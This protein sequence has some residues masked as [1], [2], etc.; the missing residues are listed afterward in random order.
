MEVIEKHTCLQKEEVFCN[1]QILR[2]LFFPH[3]LLNCASSLMG[4]VLKSLQLI[5]WE[6]MKTL[7]RLCLQSFL[8][9]T[10]NFGSSKTVVFSRYVYK[11]IASV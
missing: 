7:P 6:N 9:Y 1:C 4:R 2:I 11:K 3:V 8:S 10:V 5:M